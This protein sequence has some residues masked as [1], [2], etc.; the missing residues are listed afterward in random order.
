MILKR[1]PK[2]RACERCG[3]IAYLVDGYCFACYMDKV[4]KA[5]KRQ[6]SE[7]EEDGNE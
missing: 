2:V 3:N 1:K 5:I 6:E 4:E 7:C